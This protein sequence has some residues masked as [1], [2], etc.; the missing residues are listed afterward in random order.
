LV[1]FITGT[2]SFAMFADVLGIYY[3]NAYLV[4]RADHGFSLAAARTSVLSYGAV[5]GTIAGVAFGFIPPVRQIAFPGFSDPRWAMLVFLN[6]SG[7][8]VL[9][10]IRGIYWGNKSFALLGLVSL[11][12]SGGFA[13][14]AVAA[15]YGW[16]WRLASQV[17][18]MQVVA[19]WA[20]IVASLLF[21]AYR[22][23]G[24]PSPAYLRACMAVGWRGAGVNW[25][26]FLHQRVDQYLVEV[27][28]GP[29]ALG[30]Y[31]VAVALGEVMTQ[32]PSMLGMVIFPLTAGASD[33]AAAARSSLK[34]T[35]VIT[36][37]IAALMVPLGIFAAPLIHAL[38]G[39]A[40]DGSIQLLRLFLPAVV[41]L[42][43]LLVLNQHLAGM[44]YPLFQLGAMAA[45]LLVNVAL[46]LFLLP[47]FGPA[48]ASVAS[49]ISY[50]FWLLLITW[51]VW[52]RST[53]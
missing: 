5:L 7:M 1:W 29:K 15:V 45:G 44:G 39:N 20:C 48:G 52:R 25:L 36:L 4:A 47:R 43:A 33:Q 41:F 21:L 13:V 46:N 16:G 19:V 40:F 23:L 50:A 11:V 8:V 14:L 30:L 22:G 35:L 53:R 37:V 9:S 26:S 42:S 27:I 28:L 3:S 34:R 10:Q 32:V 2:T 51:Y 17:A 24:R 12:K 31:A 6:L 18:V 49:S 38:Y